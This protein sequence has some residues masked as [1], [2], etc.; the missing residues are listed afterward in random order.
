MIK[1]M[2]GAFL[3]ALIIT[4]AGAEDMYVGAKLGKTKHNISGADN[5]P[6]AF[7]LLGGYKVDTNLFVEVEYLDLG[8]FAAA[9]AKAIDVSGLYF[10][11]GDRPF[12][13]FAKLSYAASSL[14]AGNQ[15]QYNSAF[16]YGVGLQF[17]FGPK[18]SYRF[19]L[20]RHMLGNQLV[21]N[22]DVLSVTG[23]YRF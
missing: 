4:P 9:A 13:L 20:D 11:P 22:V 10:Y 3:T 17:E 23:L 7:G 19:G 21:N 16:T 15:T 5:S 8:N 18:Q 6:T 1:I 12:S 14:K 2:L